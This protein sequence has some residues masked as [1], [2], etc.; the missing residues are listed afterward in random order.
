MN[1]RNHDKIFDLTPFW[2]FRYQEFE[3]SRFE[4]LHHKSPEVPKCEMPKILK[5]AHQPEFWIPGV[6]GVKSGEFSL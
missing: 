5:Q 1:L 3:E 6:G 4:T 2:S